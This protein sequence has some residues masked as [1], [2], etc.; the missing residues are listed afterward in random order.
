MAAPPSIALTK[1]LR[2]ALLCVGALLL[3]LAACAPA[4]DAADATRLLR[5]LTGMP[6]AEGVVRQEVAW[7]AD[8]V[9]RA[10]DLY[11]PAQQKAALVLAPGLGREGRSDARLVA[12]ARALAH[13]GYR[14]LVPD[15]PNFQAQRVAASD[16]IV[17][18]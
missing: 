7:D 9:A 5:D 2:G 3:C 17:L 8:G 11:E 18:A 4:E 10:A 13:V 12:F 6:A 16:S 1:A 14:V 15:V